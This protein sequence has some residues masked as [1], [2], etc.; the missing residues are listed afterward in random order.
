MKVWTGYGSEHSYK[1]VM[2]GRF[3]DE[4][5]ARIAEQKFERLSEAAGSELPDLG[6]D[7][8]QRFSSGIM[9]ILDELK[10]WD[11]SRSDIENFA[12]EHTVRRNGNE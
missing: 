1:L 8:D 12:Y 5:D 10:Q 3:A 4:T 9:A 2:I 6:W 7:A 11:L